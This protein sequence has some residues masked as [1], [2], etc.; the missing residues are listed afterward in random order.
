MG[1]PDYEDSIIGGTAE[2]DSAD[3]SS[4]DYAYFGDGSPDASTMELLQE[5]YRGTN[6]NMVF[7]TDAE[8]E[9]GEA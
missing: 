3:G 5:T 8:D 4:V 2:A 7:G 1:R 9:N 6:L